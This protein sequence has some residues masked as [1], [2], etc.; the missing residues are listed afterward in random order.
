MHN[1]TL[2]SCPATCALTSTLNPEPGPP[3]LGPAL[4]WVPFA[5]HDLH[6][7][8]VLGFFHS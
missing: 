6:Q 3:V 1:L 4:C 7:A 5:F 8:L 2:F